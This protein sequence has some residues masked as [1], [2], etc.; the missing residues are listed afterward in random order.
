[1]CRGPHGTFVCDT[2]FDEIAA[3]ER[4]RKITHP[5]GDGIKALGLQPD[6]VDGCHGTV[7][8]GVENT[9]NDVSESW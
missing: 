8:P 4:A 9:S 2:G 7:R 5:V 1:M 6:Q 3:K